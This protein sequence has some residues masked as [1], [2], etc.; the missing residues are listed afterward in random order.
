[1]ILLEKHWAFEYCDF[2]QV[3]ELFLKVGFYPLIKTV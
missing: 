1:M 2:G 3:L